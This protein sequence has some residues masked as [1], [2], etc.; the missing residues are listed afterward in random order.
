MSALVVFVFS[1]E[2]KAQA[3]QKVPVRA[4]IWPVDDDRTV[5]AHLLSAAFQ[6]I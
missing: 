3:I 6:F 4:D 5:L 1:Y 2:E